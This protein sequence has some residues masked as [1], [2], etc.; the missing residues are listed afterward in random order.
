MILEILVAI[1]LPGENGHK[2][3]VIEHAIHFFVPSS[4][5]FSHDLGLTLSYIS[6]YYSST[7]KTNIGLHYYYC[8]TALL[9]FYN[10][11]IAAAALHTGGQ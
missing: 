9:V 5:N 4:T 7:I 2:K 10:H 11:A 3:L 1:L 6:G 8:L